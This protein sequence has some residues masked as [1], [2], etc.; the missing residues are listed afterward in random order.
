MQIKQLKHPIKGRAIYKL[1]SQPNQTHKLNRFRIKSIDF[2][3]FWD[4]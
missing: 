1:P 4:I 3:L 2:I